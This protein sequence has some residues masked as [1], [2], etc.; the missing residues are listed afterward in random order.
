MKVVTRF[1][2]SPTGN[3][4]IGGARTALFN[5]LFTKHYG[6]KTHLR[7]ENTD[8]ERSKPEYEQNILD[9]LKWLGLAFDP[10]GEKPLWR[11]SE[12]K[13]IYKNY[14]KKLVDSGR[15]YLSKETEGKRGEVIR[16]RNPNKKIAFNDLVRGSIEFDTTELGDMVIAKSQDEP[17]YHLA[18]VIDDFEMGITHVIRGDDHISNT[19]RQIVLQEALEFPRPLY[20]HIPLIL[21]PDRSKLSKRHGAVSVTEYH[22]RGFIPAALLNYLALLGWNPGTEDEIFTLEEL[23]RAFD[24][25]KVHKGGAIFNEEKLRWINK[26]YIEKLGGA[27]AII[28]HIP[29]ALLVGRGENEKNAIAQ[30]FF[31]RISVYGDMEKEIALGEYEYLL[32]EPEYPKELLKWEK[33]TE[34]PRKHLEKVSSLLEEV[35]DASFTKSVVKEAIMTYAEAKGKGNVLWPMRVALSGRERSPDPFTLATILGKGATVRRLRKALTLLQ[36]G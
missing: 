3:L 4:H 36:S 22:D 11:Q 17:L 27:T 29:S 24:L 9:S 35:S 21:A 13:E 28:P 19:P 14:L 18:V 20:A 34:N 7:L 31:D 23:I 8:E 32:R 10:I 30:M 15:A 1:P 12:R 2:P 16:F 6:G 26:K 33:A 5:F 25:D